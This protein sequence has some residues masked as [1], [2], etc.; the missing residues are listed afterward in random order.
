MEP[1][2][3]IGT[4]T[5]TLANLSAALTANSDKG[6]CKFHFQRLSMWVEHHFYCGITMNGFG[7]NDS[8][9]IVSNSTTDPTPNT[10]W[11]QWI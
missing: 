10:A 9:G 6:F 11:E 3:I 2:T 4:T 7:A 1:G 8:L 5:I